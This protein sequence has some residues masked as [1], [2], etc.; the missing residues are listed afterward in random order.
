MVSVPRRWQAGSVCL[1]AGSHESQG[2]EQD[3]QR[4]HVNH[5]QPQTLVL[6]L[7]LLDT[8]HPYN[9]QYRPTCTHVMPNPTHCADS[10]IGLP[11]GF[12][13]NLNDIHKIS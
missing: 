5:L 9:V 8:G 3:M 7:L 4:S 11:S 12:W 6:L 13:K 1:L 2:S 10:Q